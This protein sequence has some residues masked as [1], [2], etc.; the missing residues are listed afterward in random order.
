MSCAETISKRAVAAGLSRGA[1]TSAL[2]QAKAR[3]I[4]DSARRLLVRRGFRDITLDEVARNARVAKGTV[5][6]Y[7]QSKDKLV[8]AVFWDLADCLSRDLERLAASRSGGQALLRETVST[9]LSHFDKNRDFLYQAGIGGGGAYRLISGQTI[10]D[11]FKVNISRLENIL[12]KCGRT[13][14]PGIAET[15]R[16][17]SMIFA[18]CRHS[19]FY[20]FINGREESVELRAGK[21]VRLLLHGATRAE[22]PK[23]AGSGRKK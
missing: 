18:L 11:K 1:V 10:L 4:L 14:G 17:A 2:P 8:A 9:I 6:L 7:Y 22:L 3:R 5:F 20:R 23:R 13:G 15:R 16:T 19:V 12:K 21:I